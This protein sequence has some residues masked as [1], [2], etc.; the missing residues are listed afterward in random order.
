MARSNFCSIASSCKR[1]C[2]QVSAELHILIGKLL[3]VV[4]SWSRGFYQLL[5]P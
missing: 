1:G 5:E 3:E 4:A 2:T